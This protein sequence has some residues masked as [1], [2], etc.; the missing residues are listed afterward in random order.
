[1]CRTPLPPALLDPC[2]RGGRRRGRGPPAPSRALPW[3]PG[4]K[5]EGAGTERGERFLQGAELRLAEAGPFPPAP[6]GKHLLPG[7][8]MKAQSGGPHRQPG[9]SPSPP[10]KALRRGS[11]ALPPQT[12]TGRPAALPAPREGSA[13]SGRVAPVRSEGCSRVT[14]GSSDWQQALF[15]F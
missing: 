9:S 2:R 15:L 6:L 10:Q 11:E 5:R 3:G 4:R 13:P 12:S 1:M 8:L 7:A 14:Y